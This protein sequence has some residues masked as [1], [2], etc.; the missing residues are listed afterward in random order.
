MTSIIELALDAAFA[1]AHVM[2]LKSVPAGSG[3]LDF[4]AICTCGFE[5][6]PASLKDASDRKYAGCPV[7]IELV[8]SAARRARRLAA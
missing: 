2:V 3:A 4:T 8:A 6:I 7:E 5:S 1:S